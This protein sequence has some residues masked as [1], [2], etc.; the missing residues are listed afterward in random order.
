MYI[1]HRVHYQYSA[2]EGFGVSI[3]RGEAT[4]NFANFCVYDVVVCHVVLCRKRLALRSF[5]WT[6]V[7][8]F[9]K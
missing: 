5:V 7:T 9:E 2:L 4:A 8:R 3:L 1:F 6:A